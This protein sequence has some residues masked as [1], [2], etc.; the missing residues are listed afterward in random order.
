MRSSCY[1]DILK[2]GDLGTCIRPDQNLYK[3]VKSSSNNTNTNN[4]K[5]KYNNNNNKNNNTAHE[6][7]T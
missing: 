2:E 5:K 7:S 4:K 1:I 3:I 6:G